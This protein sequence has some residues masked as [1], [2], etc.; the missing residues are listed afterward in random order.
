[1]MKKSAGCFAAYIGDDADN[2]SC[3]FP[4]GCT[5][6]GK[7]LILAATIFLDYRYFEDKKG[8]Q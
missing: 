1:M 4:P 2:F 7:A 5:P 3:L 6:E 8:N